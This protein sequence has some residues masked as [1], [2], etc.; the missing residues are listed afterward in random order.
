VPEREL[1]AR[2][3]G[4]NPDVE[5]DHPILGAAGVHTVRGPVE[6]PARP[7]TPAADVR[8]GDRTDDLRRV[9]STV[10]RVLGPVAYFHRHHAVANLIR[11][12]V[13]T[14]FLHRHVRVPGRHHR[15]VQ[16]DHAHR[17]R[18]GRV[19]AGRHLGRA[20]RWLPEREVRV[21]RRVCL[22]RGPE[23]GRPVPR[24]A[25]YLRHVRTVQNERFAVQEHV[26]S[27]YRRR[28]R[29]DRVRQAGQPQA[30]YTLVDD[31]CLSI[32]RWTFCG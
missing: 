16:P 6:R 18:V 8:A 23:R 25:V 22:E 21:R 1:R 14:L 9:Q 27:K 3:G 24:F 29:Q 31:R 11:H 13:S 26:R 30:L 2:V 7:S 4:Q 10:H 19:T 5:A 28:E 17:V 20:V 32:D 12:R 15:H